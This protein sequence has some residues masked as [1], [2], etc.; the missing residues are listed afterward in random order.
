M[1]AGQLMGPRSG[2]AGR[3]RAAGLP[4]DG[5]CQVVEGVGE[6]PGGQAGGSLLDVAFENGAPP[7][8]VRF[9]E[10]GPRLGEQVRDAAGHV[11]GVQARGH[12]AV[13]GQVGAYPLR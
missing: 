6:A 5:G 1:S 8:P 11:R 12:P 13:D 3:G 4:A 9:D 2:G 7:W 10:A